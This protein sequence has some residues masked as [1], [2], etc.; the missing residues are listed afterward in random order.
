[1]VMIADVT[2]VALAA[3]RRV[4][5]DGGYGKRVCPLLSEEPY[6]ARPGETI[7]SEQRG[8]TRPRVAFCCQP[9]DLQ[10]VYVLAMLRRRRMDANAANTDAATDC[11]KP[12]LPLKERECLIQ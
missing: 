7:V 1:M 4:C 12:W 6:V 8:A 5:H 10:T 2:C 11:S 9:K 3:L